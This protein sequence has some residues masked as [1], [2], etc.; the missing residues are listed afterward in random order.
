M[1]VRMF[2][3]FATGCAAGIFV[4]SFISLGLWSIVF[5]VVLAGALLLTGK[6]SVT[7]RQSSAL[8]AVFLFACA[9]G[10]VRMDSAVLEGDSLLDTHV[11]TKTVIE[12]TVFQEPDVREK[13]TRLAVKTESGAGILV[14]APLHSGISYGDL[15]RATGTLRVPKSFDTGEGHLFNYPAYLA[16][17]G[18]GYEL[19]F[20]DVEKIGGGVGNPLTAIAIAIKQKY[21]EGLALALSEP[22]AGLAGGITAGDK[23]GLGP[24]LSEAFRTVGLTHIVVLSGYNIM[25]VIAF[26]ERVFAQSRLATRLSM[27]LGVALLFAFMTGLAS[28]SVRAASMA[29]IAVI[30]KATGRLYLAG[31]ALLAVALAMI[32][33]NPYVLAFDP[34]FQLS[35]IATWGLIYISPQIASRLTRVTERF[36]FREIAAATIGTQIAVLPLILYQSGML[37][38]MSLPA[39]LLVLVV[40]PYAM[41]A[42]FI[43]GLSGVVLSVVAPVVAFPAYVLLG[44][45]VKI[46]ELFSRAPFATV[47]VPVFGV[48]FLAMFYVFLWLLIRKKD[49]VG[50]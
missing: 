40:V 28:S 25:I 4:R 16:K 20:A 1:A 6:A 37:S 48:W 17:D 35:V 31:R 27:S 46:A 13:N 33:W 32:L 14:I 47:E 15:V 8:I 3:I 42:S 19:S 9:I 49:A 18:I 34:G 7:Y 45:I 24:E 12:G 2:V 50:T 30:G 22:Y 36:A 23:R 10:I 39:N 29:S 41:L 5:L 26:F 44:Y 11:G 38:L 21:L 43:A